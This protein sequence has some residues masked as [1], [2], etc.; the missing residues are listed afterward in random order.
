MMYPNSLSTV[1]FIDSA[2]S[3]QDLPLRHT[4]KEESL[5]HRTPHTAPSSAVLEE[6]SSIP[7]PWLLLSQTPRTSAQT[8]S[9]TPQCSP[10]QRLPPKRSMK[11][12]NLS[13][14]VKS[15]KAFF[16]DFF[17]KSC[18]MTDRTQYSQEKI[19][20]EMDNTKNAHECQQENLALHAFFRLNMHRSV[21][22]QCF[23]KLLLQFSGKSVCIQDIR[24]LV[25]SC[26]KR[27]F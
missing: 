27:D 25:Q 3:L 6:P 9:L 16:R 15:L 13:P 10:L 14:L 2:L 23:P 5:W 26:M 22:V 21:G 24:I 12:P 20:S 17:L 4:G 19:Q 1:R 7:F 11:L 18:R 8:H